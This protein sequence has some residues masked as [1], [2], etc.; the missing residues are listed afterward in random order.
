MKLAV[1]KCSAQML[2]LLP[3]VCTLGLAD[4]KFGGGD[5]NQAVNWSNGLPAAGNVGA[6]AVDGWNGTTV[7]G[8]GGGAIVNH[9]RGTI[10]SSD[11]FNFIRGDTWYMSGGKLFTRYFL[12]NGQYGNT[13]INVS[14]GLVELT[15]VAGNQHMGVANGG[16]L[17]ISGSA[18]LDGTQATLPVQTGGTLDIASDW[19]G[20]WTWG[21]YSG[22]EWETHFTS[23][24][25]TLGGD[26][27]DAA[28][29]AEKFDVLDSG[30]T[31][32]LKHSV[33]TAPGTVL[34]VR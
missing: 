4:T 15:D 7:F 32:E 23:G 28:A 24:Q 2:M 30:R 33:P 18:V 17:N 27:L 29:F 22:N 3:C 25:I 6:I 9:T 20:T 1:S 19:T 5:L 16:T 14:G 26:T 10:T 34:L 21:I 11:G 31:L 12:S 8:F 13:V